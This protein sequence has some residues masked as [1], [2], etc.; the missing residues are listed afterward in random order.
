MRSCKIN[1]SIVFF[2]ILAILALA[3]LSNAATFTSVTV[4]KNV[5]A[6][7]A[8]VN[9]MLADSIVFNNWSDEEEALP[10]G[11][12]LFSGSNCIDVG[13][14]P[15]WGST[16]EVRRIE[17]AQTFR[18]RKSPD[19]NYWSD[20]DANL[21]GVAIQLRVPFP[22]DANDQ[23][24]LPVTGT[25]SGTEI[26]VIS[27]YEMRNA[28]WKAL[29][30][31]P[32]D[33]KLLMQWSG[34]IPVGIQTDPN[35]SS[36]AKNADWLKFTFD[37][38]YHLT[39]GQAYALRFA[40]QSPQEVN[41]FP[42]RRIWTQ[43][44]T[45]KVNAWY[46]DDQNTTGTYRDGT[47]TMWRLDNQTYNSP[48]N[49]YP[50]WVGWD[51]DMDFAVL[52]AGSQGI[53]YGCPDGDVTRNCDVKFNDYAK[54]ASNWQSD[55]TK[56][57]RTAIEYFL[58]E[59]ND[60]PSE[61]LIVLNNSLLVMRTSPEE[62]NRPA[63]I[64]WKWNSVGENTLAQSF[65]VDSNAGMQAIAVQA[66]G[67]IAGPISLPYASEPTTSP[68]QWPNTPAPNPLKAYRI[69]IYQVSDGNT[70][71]N[72][73][74]EPDDPCI[75]DPCRPISPLIYEANGIF[76][77]RAPFYRDPPSRVNNGDWVTFVLP[78]TVELEGGKYYAFSFVWDNNDTTAATRKF[79]L[80]CSDPNDPNDPNGDGT[81]LQGKLWR[82]TAKDPNT[83]SYKFHDYKCDLEFA[84]IGPRTW[85]VDDEFNSDNKI[86]PGDINHDCKVD[87]QDM[88]MFADTWLLSNII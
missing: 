1:T 86:V 44:S 9:N 72:L 53:C 67:S 69:K 77:F 85:C 27:L 6:P 80:D 11:W 58:S 40:W 59:V 23:N 29:D 8:D 20:E 16:L 60:P 88:D 83:G 32:T 41:E 2:C 78:S 4:L 65:Y 84:I 15:N 76:P 30:T 82:R 5:A 50:Y 19:A 57:G 66:A 52:K 33:E 7:N 51:R 37:T 79:I 71:P 81:Y 55:V 10:T 63:R 39:A 70:A 25:N 12:D 13:W 14:H 42:L 3:S 68:E 46:P 54:L 73:F 38:G 31:E 47:Q 43:T 87:M 26:F 75:T 49:H 45:I 64:D 22:P 21:G 62:P 18:D 17:T 61:N 24:G 34:P 56:T 28:T 48:W 36:T 35:I 74:T